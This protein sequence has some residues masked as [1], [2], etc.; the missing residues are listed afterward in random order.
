MKKEPIKKDNKTIIIIALLVF[1]LSAHAR[2]MAINVINS[3]RTD[4]VAIYK[5]ERAK[6]VNYAAKIA[7]LSHWEGKQY[8]ADRR[9]MYRKRGVVGNIKALGCRMLPGENLCDRKWDDQEY[10]ERRIR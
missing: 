10:A 5:T 6:K 1:S 8:K 2:T 4:A 9:A 3:I 7:R